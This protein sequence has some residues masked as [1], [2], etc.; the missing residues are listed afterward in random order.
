MHFSLFE[1]LWAHL[2]SKLPNVELSLNKCSNKSKLLINKAASSY[3]FLFGISDARGKSLTRWRSDWARIGRCPA[4]RQANLNSEEEHYQDSG[5]IHLSSGR[6]CLA[7]T[8][9]STDQVTVVYID[10]I[11]NISR[12]V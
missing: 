12:P 9:H 4:K 10:D 5:L 8:T 11:D 6:Y 3:L 2:A 1:P 7:T